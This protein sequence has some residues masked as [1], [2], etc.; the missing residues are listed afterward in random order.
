[1]LG[2]DVLLLLGPVFHCFFFNSVGSLPLFI[3]GHVNDKLCLPCKLKLPGP[4]GAGEQGDIPAQ[5]SRR[6]AAGPVKAMHS[7]AGMDRI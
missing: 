4:P 7:G 2:Q 3:Y 1:M 6:Q 5:S